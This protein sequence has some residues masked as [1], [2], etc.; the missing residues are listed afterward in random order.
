[1]IQIYAG[2]YLKVKRK[3]MLVDRT[4]FVCE[5][6]PEHYKTTYNNP[7]TKFCHQCAGKIIQVVE[8][9][10]DSGRV[11]AIIQSA[12]KSPKLHR[13]DGKMA[14]GK[15]Y[16]YYIA[17]DKNL[18]VYDQTFYECDESIDGFVASWEQILATE[19]EFMS[20]FYDVM[21]EL[22]DM[23]IEYSVDCGILVG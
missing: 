12:Q 14:D 4:F 6:N 19:D 2:S 22:D 21:C 15:L 10:N 11:D 8:E 1:M 3:E 9:L 13:F 20:A 17:R 23:N 18:Q 7:L 16:L 5:H